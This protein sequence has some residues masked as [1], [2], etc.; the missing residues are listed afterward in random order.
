MVATA[1]RSAALTP[2]RHSG[3]D[4]AERAAIGQRRGAAAALAAGLA[5]A[6]LLGTN[7]P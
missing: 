7:L 6:T 2:R 1:F 3:G 5:A 4:I